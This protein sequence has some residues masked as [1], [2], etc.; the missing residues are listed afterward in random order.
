MSV[1]ELLSQHTN[2]IWL[3]QV[4]RFSELQ[5]A[6]GSGRYQDRYQTC[7]YQ[8]PYIPTMRVSRTNGKSEEPVLRV[9]F[10]FRFI[11]ALFYELIQIGSVYLFIFELGW[12]I[13]F[14]RVYR[15]ATYDLRAPASPWR[16]KIHHRML[17]V[18]LFLRII[19][20][21]S[22][23]GI[24]LHPVSVYDQVIG[25]ERYLIAHIQ[26]QCA[27]EAFFQRLKGFKKTKNITP[28]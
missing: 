7:M 1:E 27:A 11:I 4:L 17:P 5:N 26:K 22:E 19:R 25:F 10:R 24:V 2:P 20:N 16:E 28:F 8:K 21:A 9:R 14:F 18:I 13:F 23:H 15:S 12:Q 6:A 3:I